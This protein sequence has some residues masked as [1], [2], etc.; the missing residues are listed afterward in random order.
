LAFDLLIL[1][2]LTAALSFAT[3]ASA[4]FYSLGF[5]SAFV[6]AAFHYSVL[7]LFAASAFGFF[8]PRAVNAFFFA[9]FFDFLCRFASGI[10]HFRH[11]Y[12]RPPTFRRYFVTFIDFTVAILANFFIIWTRNFAGIGFFQILTTRATASAL[13]STL[14]ARNFGQ[15]STFTEYPRST[16]SLTFITVFNWRRSAINPSN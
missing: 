7:R 16:W 9:S 5:T 4:T 3:T 10:G 6:A 8:S 13:F 2:M 12:V 1:L 14:T 15:I 11:K